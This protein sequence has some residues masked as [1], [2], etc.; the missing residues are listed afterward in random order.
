MTM[1]ETKSYFPG[2]GIWKRI[3]PKQAGFDPDHLQF[4]V[5]YAIESEIKWPHDMK[6]IIVPSIVLLT[7]YPSDQ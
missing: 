6:V 4:A 1:T 5:T 7:I 3:E 2:R